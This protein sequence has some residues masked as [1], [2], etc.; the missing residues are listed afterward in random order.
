MTPRS[1]LEISLS[2]HGKESFGNVMQEIV[3]GADA[4]PGEEALPAAVPGEPNPPFFGRYRALRELGR[5]GMGI[6]WLAQ[7]TVLDIPVALKLVPEIIVHDTEGIVNLKKEVLRGMALTHPGIVRVHGFEQHEKTAGIVMEH[8]NGESLAERKARQPDRCFDVDEVRPWLEQLCAALDYAHHEARIAHRDIKPSN[9]LL[10]A[11]GR[12][13]IV[14]FGLASSLSETRSRISARM[15]IS[16]TPPYMSPQQLMGQRPTHL[17]DLYSLG[18][19]LYE[20]LAGTPPFFRGDVVAQIMHE[21]PMPLAARR[22]EFCVTNR[23]PIP[24]A[25]ERAIAACLAKD[26]MARPQTAAAILQILD[27]VKVRTAIPT[28]DANGPVDRTPPSASSRNSTGNAAGTAHGDAPAAGTD[29]ATELRLSPVPFKPSELRIQTDPPVQTLA[30][31]AETIQ[32]VYPRAVHPHAP[33]QSISLR[34]LLGAGAFL[35]RSVGV[36]IGG[37]AE[38]IMAILRPLLKIAAVIVVLWGL[39]HLK[40]KWDAGAAQRQA[41]LPPGPPAGVPAPPALPPQVI[42]LPPP[43][44]PPAPPFPAFGPQPGRPLDPPPRPPRR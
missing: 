9:L 10:T 21:L 20:L 19:T 12:V 37:L 15:G 2:S 5:G 8:V 42:V 17:D 1:V 7:D 33:R 35:L 40:Q 23:P 6:V 30:A 27:E 34:P 4:S 13:K 41:A 25:W 43:P 29:S 14:D 36:A 31:P 32:H 24:I 39:L 16:G 28:P 3:A 44:A 38:L 11:A 22:A 26:P 18:A